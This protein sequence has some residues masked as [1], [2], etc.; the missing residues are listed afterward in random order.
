M[1]WAAVVPAVLLGFGMFFAPESPRWLFKV[2]ELNS[3]GKTVYMC[4]ICYG[5][6]SK[7]P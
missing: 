3:I 1:F 5:W 4:S 6:I 2:S 7:Y